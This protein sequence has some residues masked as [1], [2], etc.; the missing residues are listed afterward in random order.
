VIRRVD[1]VSSVQAFLWAL[2]LEMAA[3]ASESDQ[4][5]RSGSPAVQLWLTDRLLSLDALKAEYEPQG[6]YGEMVLKLAYD[7]INLSYQAVGMGGAA[8][9][10]AFSHRLALIAYSGGLKADQESER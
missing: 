9:K 7:L 2:D 8:C 4:E 10:K 5:S 6:R 1:E 3:R